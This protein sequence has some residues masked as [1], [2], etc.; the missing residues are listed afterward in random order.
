MKKH[1]EQNNAPTAA[2]AAAVPRVWGLHATAMQ[3]YVI[4]NS[5]IPIGWEDAGELTDFVGSP[6]D[7]SR[8]AALAKRIGDTYENSTKMGVATSATQIWNFLNVAQVGDYVAY[9]Y[10]ES[11][12]EKDVYLGRITGGYFYEPSV[13][14]RNHRKVEWLAESVPYRSLLPV[15]RASLSIPQTF[16]RIANDV[17]ARDLLHRFGVVP[18][19]EIQAEYDKPPT[20]ETYIVDRLF[21]FCDGYK[22]Q[23]FVADALRID[24]YSA[25]VTDKG[26]DGGIDIEAERDCAYIPVKFIVQCKRVSCDIG[27]NDL[28]QLRGLLPE[29][30]LGLFVTLKGF[31]KAA[32][33]FAADHKSLILMDGETFAR[34]VLKVYKR[35]NADWQRMLALDGK[36]FSPSEAVSAPTA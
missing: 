23:Q 24:G 14:Y 34:L 2:D 3:S 15:T 30:T 12:N 36:K 19:S 17:S 27:V 16:F 1:T 21:T 4:T 20:V 32:R 26:A 28:Q 25:K 35:M 8:R 10:D 6:D 11:G 33:D 9:A 5:V 13:R 29:G 22:F 31:T 18:S 7:E